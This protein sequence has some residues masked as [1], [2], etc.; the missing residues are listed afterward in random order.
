MP[1]PPGNEQRTIAQVL[2]TVQRAKE[3]TEKV[4]VAGRQVKV[5]LMRHLFTYGPV[6]IA[7]ADQVELQ[8]TE[9]GLVPRHWRVAELGTA[10]TGTQYGLSQRG[11]ALGRYPI[12]RMNNLHGGRIRTAEIQHVDLVDKEFKKYRLN[13]GDLLFNRTNS[14]ELVGKT[15][16]FD[17]DDDY[18]FASYLIRV[19]PDL[20][21]LDPAFANYYLNAGTT[22]ARLKFMAMRAVSQSNI[23]ATKL[24]GLRIPLPNLD[25]QK[26]I[27]ATLV[28]ADQKVA[29]EEV[30]KQALD[31]LFSTLLHHLMTGK[32]RVKDLA[33]P[34]READQ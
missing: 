26:E 29:A 31:S 25:E 13:C 34:D 6:P 10:I 14:F 3:A 17:L 32:L 22:Q 12:L 18:V 5:S 8:E 2:L 21:Q 27:A 20:D 15:S 19:V 4:V 30:R 11:E 9:I 28:A 1:L 23:N 7:T 33:V 16:L 24:R